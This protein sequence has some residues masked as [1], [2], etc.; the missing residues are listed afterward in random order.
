MDNGW[1]VVR[2]PRWGQ[3]TA[4]GPSVLDVSHPPGCSRQDPWARFRTSI[5]W[6]GSSASAPNRTKQ[7]R[8]GELE[9]AADL[10]ERFQLNRL[11]RV[12]R[13]ERRGTHT[14]GVHMVQA[15]SDRKWDDETAELDGLQHIRYNGEDF[16]SF[17]LETMRW[18]TV[19]PQALVTKHRLDQGDMLNQ[20]RKHYFT[21]LCPYWLNKFVKN[22]KDFLL[23]TASQGVSSPEDIVLSGHLPRDRFLPLQ[24]RPF[25]EEGRR[26][27][28]RGRRDGRDAPQPRWNLPDDSPPES[29]GD[30]RRGEHNECVF[31]LSGMKDDI[32]TKL[33]RRS[34]LTFSL[35]QRITERLLNS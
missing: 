28:P 3:R 32:V 27:A 6:V 26:A 34:I 15:I 25:L 35:I 12:M 30:G 21:E 29:G 31:R 14:T 16:L 17:E 33:E 10:S 11:R 7:K 4:L 1:P 2:V 13:R 9:E 22:A 23:R 5:D 24:S 8:R 20:Y 19:Q 18:I